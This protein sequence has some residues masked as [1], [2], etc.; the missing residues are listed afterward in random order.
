MNLGIQNTNGP[1]PQQARAG[2]NKSSRVWS[3]TKALKLDGSGD[4][5]DANG[6]MSQAFLRANPWTISMWV[7]W[8]KSVASQYFLGVDSGSNSLEFRIQWRWVTGG[9]A[10]IFFIDG[11]YTSVSTGQFPTYFADSGLGYTGMSGWKHLCITHAN[12][13]GSGDDDRMT[14]KYYVD[15]SE[16]SSGNGA[17]NATQAAVT[18]DKDFFF[19]AWNNNGTLGTPATA[20]MTGCAIFS[21]ALDA[22]NVTA[23]YNSGTP[24]DL[25]VNHGDYNQSDKLSSYYPLEDHAKDIV[26]TL[27]DATLAGDPEYTSSNIPF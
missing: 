23:V 16:I 18:A 14:I 7:N 19:G 13:S 24:F 5:I 15:A 22:D 11:Q 1:T 10:G 12:A 4:Y 27:A 9:G 3:G 17:S 25:S 26:G 20:Y 2:V 6:A 21:T 8:D